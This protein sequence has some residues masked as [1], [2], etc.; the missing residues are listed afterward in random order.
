VRLKAVVVWTTFS[1]TLDTRNTVG[2]ISSA[3]THSAS[4]GIGGVLVEGA[5]LA[6]AQVVAIV[7]YSINYIKHGAIVIV[8]EVNHCTRGLL[9]HPGRRCSDLAV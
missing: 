3:P 9:P 7:T 4:Q 1:S 2:G 8:V 6:L 5:G